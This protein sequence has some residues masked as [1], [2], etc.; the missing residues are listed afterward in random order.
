VTSR[1]ANPTTGATDETRASLA[2]GFQ[3][4]TRIAFG[5]RARAELG[6]TAAGFGGRAALVT[7]RSFA[8]G[9]RA[10]ELEALLAAAGVEIVARIVAAGEPDSDAV[11]GAATT[12]REARADVL[13]AVGG[14]S[15][16]DLAKAAALLPDAARLDGHLAGG[17]RVEAPSGLPVIALPTTA[18]SGSEVSHAAIVLDR[19]AGRKRGIRGPGVAARVAIVDADLLDGLPPEVAASSGFDAV[20]HAI[21]T[22][23]SAAATPHVVALAGVALERLLRAV[24]R[25]LGRDV[26]AADRDDAAY[27]ALLMGINLAA[28]TT[29]LPHRL[30]YPLGARTGCGHAE[31]VAALMPAWLA[32]TVAIAPDRLARLAV[33]A[34]IAARDEPAGAAAERLR[35]RIEDHLDATG[36][37]RGLAAFGVAIADL[38]G[39]VGAVE[40][41]LAND[42]GPTTPP[43]LRALYLASM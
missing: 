28:S 38:D 2:F 43:D 29:C 39:L 35:A 27:A 8:A 25:T 12:L 9:P 5:R 19:S 36:M 30:Q 33:A 23:V 24:P 31:G 20:A 14:G 21:E 4:P 13:I 41:S 32:R 37:R 6:T 18:G 3:L 26:E 22:A 34:G 42:P 1:L 15:P 16:I 40:G 17:V 10:A 11:I 7:R